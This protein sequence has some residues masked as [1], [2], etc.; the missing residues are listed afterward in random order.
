MFFIA[1]FKFNLV[2]R[3][4]IRKF[5]LRIFYFGR[6][7]GVNFTN[8]FCERKSRKH[9]KTDNLTVFLRFWA[10][11]TQK[12][13]EKRWWNWHSISSCDINAKIKARKRRDGAVTRTLFKLSC[14]SR[15]QR[16]FSAC[17][18]IFKVLTLVGSNQ[19]NFFDNATACNKLT[20]KTLVATQLYVI[21][22]LKWQSIRLTALKGNYFESSNFEE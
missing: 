11:S 13:H 12:L 1:T 8:S 15:F 4:S 16:A 21:K 14:D 2:V 19:S 3:L 22:P 5:F 9:K 20:L 18:C 7:F 10:P 17:S 6:E